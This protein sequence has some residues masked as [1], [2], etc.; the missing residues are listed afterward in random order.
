[1]KKTT[2]VVLSVLLLWTLACDLLGGG[3]APSEPKAP[4]SPI[5]LTD[6]LMAI[7]VCKAIPQEDIEAVMGRKLVSAPAQF[8]YYDTPGTNGCSYDAGSD[9]GGN[10]YFGY[11]IFTPI[12]V[13]NDQPLSNDVE[14]REIG[15]NAYFNNGADARQLWVQVSDTVAFVVAFGDKPNEEGAK[16]LAKLLVAA[17]K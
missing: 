10:A 13:Y 1:M 17:I 12:E 15:L 6:D 9:S 14:V 11:V 5:T 4:I 16:S 2:F 3:G 8:G 7:D